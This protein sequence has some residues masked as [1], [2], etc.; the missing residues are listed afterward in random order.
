M[1]SSFDV[2][3]AYADTDVLV[4]LAKLKQ[5]GTTGVTLTMKN[6]FGIT[7][8]SLQWQAC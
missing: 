3:R 7:P 1:F 5:H 8:S 6:M 2:N 4:S